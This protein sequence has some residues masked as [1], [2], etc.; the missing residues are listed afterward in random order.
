MV[1]KKIIK[2]ISLINRTRFLSLSV[3]GLGFLKL[4]RE[5]KFTFS[6]NETHCIF[7]CQTFARKINIRKLKLKVIMNFDIIINSKSLKKVFRR[8]K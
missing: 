4:A 8:E 6:Y 1:A 2:I 7:F 3:S 5:Q